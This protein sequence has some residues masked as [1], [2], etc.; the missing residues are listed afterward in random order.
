MVPAVDRWNLTV[1]CGLSG[2]KSAAYQ[3]SSL[4]IRY[5]H[6][7]GGTRLKPR[8]RAIRTRTM[9]NHT[10]TRTRGEESGDRQSSTAVQTQTEEEEGRGSAGIKSLAIRTLDSIGVDPS[11][12]PGVEAAEFHG[13]LVSKD[14]FILDSVD[15]I[16]QIELGEDPDVDIYLGQYF[17]VSGVWLN[18]KR[19]IVDD[20]EQTDDWDTGTD[21]EASR[22][23]R[24]PWCPDCWSFVSEV[25]V[26]HQTHA[27]KESECARCGTSVH[28]RRQ[29]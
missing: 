13:C 18:E 1:L 27:H 9:Q 5:S 15:D 21:V 29:I 10:R 20:I 12:L 24:E 19:I 11:I 3:Y 14:P 2:L 16:C 8:K 23:D 22:D 4:P 6:I 17:I 28:Y 7:V 26:D 25:V